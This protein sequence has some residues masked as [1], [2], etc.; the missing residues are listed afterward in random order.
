MD[1]ERK[2]EAPSESGPPDSLRPWLKRIGLGLL[3]IAALRLMTAVFFGRADDG[4]EIDAYRGVAVYNQVEVDSSGPRMHKAAD[5]FVFGVK[6]SDT[7][8]VRRFFHEV[9]GVDIAEQLG[10]SAE[11]FNDNLKHGAFNRTVGLLQY[12]NGGDEAPRTGDLIVLRRAGEARLGIICGIE[13]FDVEVIRQGARG[14]TRTTLTLRNDRDVY[15]LD[16][17]GGVLGWMRPRVEGP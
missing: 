11:W 12:R 7:E 8:F 10:Q 6:W 17:P 15:I 3:I 5:G 14:G 16:A 9:H 13:D 4:A 1:K 2:A